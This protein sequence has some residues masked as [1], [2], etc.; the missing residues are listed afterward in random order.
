VAGWLL[1][2]W[3][4]AEAGQCLQIR[5]EDNGKA[6]NARF[7][8]S[9]KMGGVVYKLGRCQNGVIVPSWL[10]KHDGL[11]ETEIRVRKEVVQ[12]GA[13]HADMFND[14]SRWLVGVDRSPF[15][16]LELHDPELAAR[17][18]SERWRIAYYWLPEGTGGDPVFQVMWI[19]DKKK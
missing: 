7:D 17:A 18:R 16:G 1:A 3:L 19:T 8:V 11:V 12:L 14:G 4:V 2:A 15:R 13:R 10:P 6:R 9:V 5:L